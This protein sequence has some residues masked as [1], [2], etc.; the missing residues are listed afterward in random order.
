M[1]KKLNG[2]EDTSVMKGEK[3][4]SDWRASSLKEILNPDYEPPRW[5]MG[6]LL[7]EQSGA[8][9]SG[10]PHAGKSLTWLAAAME[11]VSTHKVW[12]YFDASHVRSVLY[13]ET[14]DPRV[15]IEQRVRDF[16]VGL[17]LDP[18]NPPEGFH[19]AATGPF[20]LVKSEKQLGAL[21]ESI[22]PDWVVVS[23]LQGLLNGRD[24]KEQSDRSAVNALLVRFAR[25]HA[26]VVLLTHSP[27]DRSQ[28]RAAGSIT[29][30]ANFPTTIAFRQEKG[31]GERIHHSQ[32]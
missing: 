29:Q 6:D 18:D 28:K 32:R 17:G 5:I 9:V 22:K 13:I 27:Q 21:A 31:V 1:S 30:A 3:F 10:Q 23:T 19:L 7:L 4:P 11:S 12:N 24:W 14:E 16:A 20:D 26:P 15:L 8:L 25:K 2:G